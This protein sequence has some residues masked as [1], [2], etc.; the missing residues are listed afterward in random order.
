MNVKF[1]PARRA[2]TSGPL[3]VSFHQ[4]RG[5]A[6]IYRRAYNYDIRLHHPVEDRLQV[7]LYGAAIVLEAVVTGVASLDIESRQRRQVG[8]DA[9][10]GYRLE[11]VGH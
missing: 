8:L 10:F 5:R 9:F 4:G 11:A 2:T 7:V 6:V 1:L 3:Q